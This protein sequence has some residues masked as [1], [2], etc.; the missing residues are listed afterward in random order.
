MA[1]RKATKCAVVKK[2]VKP[3]AAGEKKSA[4]K[5][6]RKTP[7]KQYADIKAK[8]MAYA[9]QPPE[10][11]DELLSGLSE[12]DRAM[13]CIITGYSYREQNRLAVLKDLGINDEFIKAT[14]NKAKHKLKN[15]KKAI[16]GDL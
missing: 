5:C 14:V 2:V 3:K 10:V 6:K 13:F 12:H 15:A 4:A 16:R 7:E 9:A 1:N 11:V 8:F